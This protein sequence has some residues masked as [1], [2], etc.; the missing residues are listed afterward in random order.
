[1]N[2]L[3]LNEH[4]LT[5]YNYL[6]VHYPEILNTATSIKNYYD[7]YILN[8]KVHPPNNSVEYG[9]S[10]D[11][12]D[13]E[14]TIGFDCYHC[15]LFRFSDQDIY[16]EL[17]YTVETIKGIMNDDLL[18]LKYIRDDQYVRSHIIENNTDNTF[19]F[20]NYDQVKF[21]SWSGKFDKVIC[22]NNESGY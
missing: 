20:D 13:E 4:S 9:L 3:K 15:H 22:K 21:I 17:E 1:M 11:T 2:K 5:V 6:S 18:L 19:D 7:E 8:I 14:I 12:D 16:E 10:L